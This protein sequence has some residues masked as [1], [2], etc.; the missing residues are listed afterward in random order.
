MR[1]NMN[2][3]IN[4]KLNAV[5]APLSITERTWL[6]MML[7]D[8]TDTTTLMDAYVSRLYY[9][10]VNPSYDSVLATYRDAVKEAQRVYEEDNS[11]V[12]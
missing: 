4:E 8:E 7:M 10:V 6:L 1:N 3:Q 5:I 2:L 9:R 11:N 12:E